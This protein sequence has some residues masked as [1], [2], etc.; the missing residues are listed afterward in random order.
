MKPSQ[1]QVSRAASFLRM[2][3]RSR[4][5]LVAANED[6]IKP[7]MD[8]PTSEDNSPLVFASHW[9]RLFVAQP[10]VETIEEDAAALHG[11]FSV[12]F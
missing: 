9:N 7:T 8:T 11:D 12:G 6:P 1:A 2:H 4:G 10:V 5:Q 3:A